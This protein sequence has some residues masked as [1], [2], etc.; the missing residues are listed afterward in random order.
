MSQ[1]TDNDLMAFVMMGGASQDPAPICG[2]RHSHATQYEANVDTCKSS[3][4]PPESYTPPAESYTPATTSSYDSSSYS[5][6][7]CGDS[8][9]GGGGGGGD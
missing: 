2:N 3:Y 9:G 5:S 8:G 1:Q 7:S 6:S 4:T